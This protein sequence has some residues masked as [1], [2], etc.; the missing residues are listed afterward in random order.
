MLVSTVWGLGTNYMVF[1]QLESELCTNLL[2]SEADSFFFPSYQ[3]YCAVLTFQTQLPPT[4]DS[5]R[6]FT[7]PV[8]LLTKFPL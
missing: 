3:A 5:R 8:C 7:V 4:R 1:F 2:I 6:T